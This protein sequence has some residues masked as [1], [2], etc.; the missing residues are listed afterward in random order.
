MT[1]KLEI[2]LSDTEEA[3]VSLLQQIHK[4]E[5]ENQNLKEEIRLLKWSL[6]EHD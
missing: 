6:T 5:T 3:I 4:L 2:P 1:S